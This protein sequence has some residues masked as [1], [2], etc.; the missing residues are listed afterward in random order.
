MLPPVLL[1]DPAAELD[2]G[3]DWA[4]RGWLDTGE[5]ITAAVWTIPAGL[6]LITSQIIGDKT[7]A[8][9]GGG[10]AGTDYIIACRITTSAGRT[11]ER[12]MTLRVRER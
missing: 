7:V 10:T 3:F 11:D 8:W 4:E 6:T 1:K 5:T 9:L 12:S 2:Y